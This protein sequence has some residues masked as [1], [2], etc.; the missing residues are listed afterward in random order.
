MSPPTLLD[1]AALCERWTISLSTLHRMI[2]QG[3]VPPAS[4]GSAAAIALAAGGYRDI[5][6]RMQPPRRH[7]KPRSKRHNMATGTA[8]VARTELFNVAEDAFYGFKSTRKEPERRRM[9]AAA[10]ALTAISIRPARRKPPT[11]AS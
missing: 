9:L 10:K 8:T 7:P 3:A 4:A 1:T 5:R 6:R 2:R 11:K